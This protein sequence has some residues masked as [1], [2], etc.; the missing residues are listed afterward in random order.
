MD[1]CIAIPCDLQK[2]GDQTRYTVDTIPVDTV[3]RVARAVPF[4]LPALGDRLDLELLLN[5]VD[6]LLIPGGLTNVHP[7][8]YGRATTERDG[9]LDPARDMTTLP[10]MEAALARGLPMLMTCRGF[11][12]L[13]VALGGSLKRE[14]EDLP[15]EKKHGTP[16][17]A[18]TEDERYR[19][20]HGL[21]VKPGGKLHS[22]LGKERIDV[23]SLH[24]QLVDRLAP[25]LLAEGTA[26]DGS[27]EAVTV[28]GA[29]G[30]ALGVVFHPEYWGERDEPSFMILRAFAAA[31]HD[32]AGRKSFASAAE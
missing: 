30:F 6:G 25:S 2:V 3:A 21:N 16:E 8:T 7:G 26:D 9:P 27:I 24:S 11:Q 28:R 20:R 23:N 22:I 12:E 31:V 14:P 18:K 15:E 1:A 29:K 32:Y 19:I 17:S 4:L 10:L 5:R 13:N